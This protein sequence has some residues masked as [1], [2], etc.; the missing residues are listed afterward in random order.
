GAKYDYNNTNYM[1][2]G[3]IIERV[4]KKSY[5]AFMHEAIFVPAGMTSTFV[6]ENPGAVPKGRA[7]ACAIGYEKRKKAWKEA[8]GVPPQRAEELLTV[9]D[10]GIWTNLVDMAK[11]DAALRGHKLIKPATMKLA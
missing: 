6:Y 2:L 11:W 9:G 7:A 1:L 4:S 5:G 10:G 3:L 8:W